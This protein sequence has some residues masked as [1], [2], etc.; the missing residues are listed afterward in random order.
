M[1]GREVALSRLIAGAVLLAVSLGLAV[2]LA[3]SLARDVPIWFLGRDT[4]ADVVDLWVEQTS[5]NEEGDR[6]FRYYVRYQF[7]PAAGQPI[8]R[9]M[10]LPVTEWST[11]S[12]GGRVKIT[13]FPPYPVHNRIEEARYMPVLACAYVPLLVAC[14]AGLAASWHLLETGIAGA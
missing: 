4:M 10:T 8:S 11:L 9:T 5:E 13:Y 3:I 12:K 6:T 2:F 14:A 1:N 7:T